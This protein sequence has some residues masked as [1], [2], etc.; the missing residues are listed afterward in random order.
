[1]RPK[2]HP[3]GVECTRCSCAVALAE[4]ESMAVRLTNSPWHTLYLPSLNC[5]CTSPPV[6]PEVRLVLSGHAISF[7]PQASSVVC[8]GSR[9]AS[10]TDPAWAGL[11]IPGRDARHWCGLPSGKREDSAQSFTALARLARDYRATLKEKYGKTWMTRNDS[12]S[13]GVHALNF[14][15]LHKVEAVAADA[16][17]ATVAQSQLADAGEGPL[18]AEV[19]DQNLGSFAHVGAL[20]MVKALVQAGANVNVQSLGGWTPLMEAV[21]PSCTTRPRVFEICVVLLRANADVTLRTAAGRTVEQ[22]AKDDRSGEMAR[23]LHQAIA[24][25]TTESTDVP[26][27]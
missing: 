23:T 13:V 14:T 3:V 8:Q 17:A 19:R 12:E 1:M 22:V 7:R 24:E 4:E 15:E 10:H 16:C 2:G 20:A 26:P 27:P 6:P 11:P 5:L 25:T 9:V 21:R 18:S